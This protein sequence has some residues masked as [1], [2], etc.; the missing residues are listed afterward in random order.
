MH[1]GTHPSSESEGNREVAFDFAIPVSCRFVRREKSRRVESLRII[2][3]IWVLDKHTVRD[4]GF[5]WHGGCEKCL[6]RTRYY[7]TRLRLWEYRIHHRHRLWLSHVVRLAGLQ[8][9]ILFTQLLVST[10]KWAQMKQGSA[11][12][13][14]FNECPQEGQ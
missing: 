8:G 9:A 14:F 1:T 6:E 13:N 5:R 10:R 7:Q 4:H 3:Q 2:E 12:S 11:P